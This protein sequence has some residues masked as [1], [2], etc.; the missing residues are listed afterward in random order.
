MR[1]KGRLGAAV[2]GVAA[3]GFA[4][5]SGGGRPYSAVAT[6]SCL[7]AQAT[8][9]LRPSRAAAR[10]A[11][12][13]PHRA[14]VAAVAR[15]GSTIGTKAS[16]GDY[17]LVLYPGEEILYFHFTRSEREAATL[18]HGYRANFAYQI[19]S[20]KADR[21]VYRK[22]NVVVEWDQHEPSSTERRVTERCLRTGRARTVVR[23]W[24]PAP[25]PQRSAGVKPRLRGLVPR[26]ATVVHAWRVAAGG[27]IVPEIAVQWRRVSLMDGPLDA[28]EF[29]LWQRSG[30]A[31]WTLGYSLHLPQRVAFLHAR[32]GDVNGDGHADLLLFE[33]MGGSAGCGVYRLLANVGGRID[34]LLVRRGCYDDTRIWARRGVLQAFD[35][36][37]KDPSTKN[38][39]HCCWTAWRETTMRWRGS[40]LV[41]V[42]RRRVH[43]LPR[44]LRLSTY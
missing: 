25:Q 33:D 34:Q 2:I 40:R 23:K 43:S 16:G 18:L 6:V 35:G 42:A 28:A 41:S 31:A 30:R 11:R 32:T 13:G 1:V 17:Q 5:C 9:L 15:S 39:I 14:L 29:V 7:R 27:G 36:V 4:G 37:L 19:G 20:E 44:A 21:L 38:Q 8:A 22:R 24:R 10:E 26:D 12:Y 3:I